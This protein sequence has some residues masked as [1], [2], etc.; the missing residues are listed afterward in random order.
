MFQCFMSVSV[1]AI[2]YHET[3]FRLKQSDSD[4]PT[5]IHSNDIIESAMQ[6]NLGCV[7]LTFEQTNSAYR[8]PH[9]MNNVKL[10]HQIS[11][12]IKQITRIIICE[13]VKIQN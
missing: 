8:S 12:A 11:N 10:S 6:F 7:L 2:S 13:M 5:A 9:S 4:L 3:L 1:I